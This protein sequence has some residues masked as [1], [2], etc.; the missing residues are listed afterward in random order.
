MKQFLVTYGPVAE[1]RC[2][3]CR[4]GTRMVAAPNTEVTDHEVGYY[5]RLHV[6][7]PPSEPWDMEPE[8]VAS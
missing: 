6:C 4:K 3:A 5:K 7:G 8:G 2:C 1:I